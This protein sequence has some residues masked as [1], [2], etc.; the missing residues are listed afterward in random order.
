[1]PNEVENCNYEAENSHHLQVLTIE[2]SSLKD[3]VN[4]VAILA[5]QTAE[6]VETLSIDSDPE[7]AH[8]FN[9]CQ[10]GSKASARFPT[11]SSDGPYSQSVSEIKQSTKPSEVNIGA[12]PGSF[13]NPILTDDLQSS[14][15]TVKDSLQRIRLPS[16]QRLQDSRAGIKRADQ[17][18]YNVVAKCGR[19]VET[20][21]KILQQ[22]EDP[23]E[24]R[25]Q[26]IQDLYCVMVAHIRYLQDEYSSLLVNSTVNSDTAR[27]FRSFR[28]NTSGFDRQA[29]ADL[30]DA[31]AI[32]SAARDSGQQTQS[33]RG[34][35]GGRYSW[36]GGAGR[37]YRGG[38]RQSDAYQGMYNQ[39]Q[40]PGRNS[41]NQG[42]SGDTQNA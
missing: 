8:G 24:S 25:P 4:R 17:P 2:I 5:Q 15:Q 21:L 42:A 37:G 27:I 26:D 33:N 35:R 12:T 1:M 14:F 10:D 20:G 16:D 19:Y 18:L 29:I 7:K 13:P 6:K 34:F 36:R 31:A 22:F 32:V 23:A 39:R 40:F 9:K 11:S 3:T 38:F 28:R 30:R 41:Y